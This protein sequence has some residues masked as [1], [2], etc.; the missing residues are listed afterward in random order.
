MRGGLTA[1]TAGETRTYPSLGVGVAYRR[2]Q[3]DYGASFDHEDA[4]ATGHRVSL[5]VEF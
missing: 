5:G 3:L 4:L 2:L 1:R